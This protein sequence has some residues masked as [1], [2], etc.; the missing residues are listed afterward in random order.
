MFS[1]CIEE[2]DGKGITS[3]VPGELEGVPYR[4]KKPT[5]LTDELPKRTRQGYRSFFYPP[6]YDPVDPF[7][8]D[9]NVSM[10][11]ENGLTDFPIVTISEPL[12]ESP[13]PP[14]RLPPEIN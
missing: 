5:I 12:K 8:E 9:D 4:S 13:P 11:S 1:W 7:V 3:L 2:R 6:S 14:Y 10:E